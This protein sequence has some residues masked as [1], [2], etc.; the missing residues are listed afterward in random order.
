MQHTRRSLVRTVA[1]VNP[2]QELP[3]RI[4]MATLRDMSWTPRTI[5]G[6]IRAGAALLATLMLV[7][8]PVDF[9]IRLAEHPVVAPPRVVTFLIIASC[10]LL[11]FSGLGLRRL[12]AERVE[13]EQPTLGS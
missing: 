12:A 7:S 9:T 5:A 13:R 2:G 4:S 8:L 1:G 6:W 3:S 10:M 11:V